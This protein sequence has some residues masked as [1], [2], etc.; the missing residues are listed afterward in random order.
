M[1]TNFV[2]KTINELGL[3]WYYS[4]YWLY[5]YKLSKNYIIPYF[6]K[7]GFDPSGKSICEIGSAEGGVL[8]AFA[9]YGSQNCL[10]T[11]IVQSRLDAGR[12]IAEAF[13]FPISFISHNILTDDIPKEWEGS[14]DLVILRDVIEH[15][16][17]P[18]L[19]LQKIKKLLKIGGYLY[20]TFPPYYSPFG[21]H[22]HQ[23][24]N[25]FSK[26]PYLHWIPDPIFN[27]FLENGR[28]A[29]VEEVVRLRSIRLTI[30]KFLS[31]VKLSGMSIKAF[32]FFLVRP[33]YKYKFGLNPVR[34]PK[35]LSFNLIREIFATEASF[36]LVKNT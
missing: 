35:F 21:G 14:F 5:Q 32:E 10:A 15:L 26:I 31:A 34:L 12:V 16:E 11:D 2:E 7:I 22:Q 29:D 36:I 3:S 24:Q 33:V 4:Y 9:E 25:F 27:L 19:A 17:E 20:V 6:Q 1:D 23:I 28:L 13:N 18:E 30:K 8:F